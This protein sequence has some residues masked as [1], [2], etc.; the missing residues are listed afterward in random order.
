[1][2]RIAITGA[3]G[4][5]EQELVHHFNTLA[6]FIVIPLSHIEC[7][8]TDRASVKKILAA[9]Q[10]DILINCAVIL[11][12]DLCERDQDHCFAANQEGVANLV[13]ATDILKQPL[14]FVQVSSSEV[15]G[16]VHEGEYFING[17]TESDEPKPSSAYQR[18]ERSSEEL[19]IDAGARG[20][21]NLARWFIP[22]LGWLYGKGRKTYVEYFYE[23]LQ[24]D[25]E[26]VV[27]EDQWRSP[28]WAHHAAQ[29]IALLLAQNYASGIFT[30]RAP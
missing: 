11:D 10:S 7:D 8:V 19:I 30:L 4:L 6:D 13:Y 12:V 18:P 3:S 25:K 29:W 15:L 16:R 22:R 14:T 20:M 27:I 5:L 26:L 1:M 2:T 23:K 17:Y 9:H 24:D 21:H 28:I